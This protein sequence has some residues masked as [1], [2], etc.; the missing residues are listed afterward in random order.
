MKRGRKWIRKGA[1]VTA[2]VGYDHVVG[3][4]VV[5]PRADLATCSYKAT[6][7]ATK[8]G[9]SLATNW[10]WAERRGANISRHTEGVLWIRGWHK[11]ESAVLRAFL[12]AH[13]LRRTAA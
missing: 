11:P 13:A 8:L 4:T 10:R 2:L 12:A 9:A 1:Q 7:D 5:A 6:V 3:A